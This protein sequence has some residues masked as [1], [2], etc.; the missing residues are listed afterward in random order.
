MLKIINNGCIIAHNLVCFFCS[1]GQDMSNKVT[2]QLP[3]SDQIVTLDISQMENTAI[4]HASNHA[5]ELNE[6]AK[7]IVA[8]VDNGTLTQLLT[9]TQAEQINEAER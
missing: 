9:I 5:E 3:G 8:N 6:A 7:G 2:V 4:L 1:F